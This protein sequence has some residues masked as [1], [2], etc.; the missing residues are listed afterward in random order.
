MS[1]ARIQ[2]YGAVKLSAST[3]LPFLTHM[4]RRV[5]EPSYS[6][7]Q[8]Q[9]MS[10]WATCR[11]R[12]EGQIPFNVPQHETSCICHRRNGLFQNFVAIEFF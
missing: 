10:K 1:P 11:P 9:K 7:A 6:V 12:V 2:P 8:P 3:D 5:A 4:K